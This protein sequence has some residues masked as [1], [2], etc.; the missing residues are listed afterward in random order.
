MNIE[1]VGGE[2]DGARCMI[3]DHAKVVNVP[4]YRCKTSEEPYDG[5]EYVRTGKVTLDGHWLYAARDPDQQM[6][7]RSR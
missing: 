5:V 7:E 2:F 4:K 1:L 3:R 6:R